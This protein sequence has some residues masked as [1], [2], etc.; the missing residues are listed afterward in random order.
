[1]SV[2]IPLFNHAQY[3]ARAIQSVIAQGE[4]VRELI[5]IDDG[6]TDNSLIVAQEA[7]KAAHKVQVRHQRNQGA[8][9]TINRGI[10][11]A[12]GDLIAILNSDDFYLDGRLETLVEFIDKNSHVSLVGS[13][14]RFIDELDREQPNDWYSQGMS[15]LESLSYE[16][17]ALMNANVFVTTSNFLV[18]RRVFEEVGRFSS[19]RYAHDLEFLLRLLAHGKHVLIHQMPLVAYR[20]HATNTIKENHA[21]IRAELALIGAFFLQMSARKITSQS[22]RDVQL[23]QVILKKHSLSE[24]VLICLVHFFSAPLDS[25]E[26]NPFDGDEELRQAVLA[27]I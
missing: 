16:P 8:H 17:A 3:V 14:V 25:L 11:E 5:V 26:N 21:A 1:M 7:A 6:S 20:F 9:A 10:E 18:R 22:W 27:A 24:A 23:F 15:E 13:R 2:I 12:T 19:L 4:I